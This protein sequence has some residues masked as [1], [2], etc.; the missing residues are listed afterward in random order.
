MVLNIERDLKNSFQELNNV[1]SVLEEISY[2]T[3]HWIKNT[4]S[5]LV[6]L[7]VHITPQ[8]NSG[9]ARFFLIYI[10]NFILLFVSK[11]KWKVYTHKT[12]LIPQTIVVCK[13]QKITESSLQN[14]ELDQYLQDLLLPHQENFVSCQTVQQLS[15][16][17]YFQPIEKCPRSKGA[18][19]CSIMFGNLRQIYDLILAALSVT[20][21]FKDSHIMSKKKVNQTF[22]SLL[23]CSF[24]MNNIYTYLIKPSHSHCKNSEWMDKNMENKI[25]VNHIPQ[26]GCPSWG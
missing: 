13:T 2:G 20:N 19:T 22:F 21:R 9:Y 14:K 17:N 1:L 6:L 25:K 16:K 18:L 23:F 10:I 3:W 12:L 7:S 5:K 4:Y 26:A 24:E 15:C 11:L 8:I